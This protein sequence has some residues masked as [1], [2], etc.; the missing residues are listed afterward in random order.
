MRDAASFEPLSPRFARDVQRGYF[1]HA[2][3]PGS[4]GP[5]FT[6]MSEDDPGYARDRSQAWHGHIE[7]N[8]PDR[9]PHP[10]V[11]PLRGA[12]MATLRAL[13]RGYAADAQKVW[14]EGVRLPQADAASFKIQDDFTGDADAHDRTH[15]WQRGQIITAIATA[16]AR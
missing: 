12:D 2:E 16:T 10:V 5:S 6:L 15:V 7:V 13:G 9:G 14:Y 3:I 8:Q 11:R 1:E 4:H